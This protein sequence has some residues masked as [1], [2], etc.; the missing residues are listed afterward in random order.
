MFSAVGMCGLVL[1]WT[2]ALEGNGVAARLLMGKEKLG[3]IQKIVEDPYKK[4]E[5]CASLYIIIDQSDTQTKET[6]EF[7]EKGLSQQNLQLLTEFYKSNCG[8]SENPDE[9]EK[10]VTVVQN[11]V[12]A[13]DLKQKCNDL[14]QGAHFG[15]KPFLNS[16]CSESGNCFANL[17][18]EL[19]KLDIKH[20]ETRKKKICKGVGLAVAALAYAAYTTVRL[21]NDSPE[22]VFAWLCQT[23]A[24]I[25]LT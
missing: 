2:N 18:D 6:K 17:K 12:L 3:V 22:Q 10:Q 7:V 1:G 20:A 19:E 23:T 11:R 25:G 4:A 8:G 13:Q 5:I 24:W 21:D 15:L 14:E 16:L 9:I